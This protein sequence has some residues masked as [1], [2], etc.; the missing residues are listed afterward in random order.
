MKRQNSYS[1]KIQGSETVR[2]T[3]YF[4]LLF[5]FPM[6]QIMFQPNIRTSKQLIFWIFRKMV[7]IWLLTRLTDFLTPGHPDWG[8]NHGRRQGWRGLNW[9]SQTYSLAHFQNIIHST[10]WS[11]K[12]FNP[13]FLVSCTMLLTD[14]VVIIPVSAWVS[15]TKS[16]SSTTKK[17]LSIFT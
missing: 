7:S 9:G 13:S 14:M 11:N 3:I 2:A 16:K 5:P 8:G 4:L 1:Q 17:A 6:I 10:Q 15:K 12:L